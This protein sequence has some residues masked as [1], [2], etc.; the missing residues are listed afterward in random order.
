MEKIIKIG[1][2]EIKL[3][4]TAMNLLIYQEEF[5]EDMFN[6]KGLIL[7]AFT[8]NEITFKDIPSLLMLK[9][10]WTMARTADPKFPSFK[11]WMES[12]DEVPMIDIYRENIDMFMSNMMTRSDIKN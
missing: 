1:D 6:A 3:K 11:V 7:D 12:L 5:G 4:A 8:N 2:N 9:I 10:L